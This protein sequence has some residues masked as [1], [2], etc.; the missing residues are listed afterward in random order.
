[1]VETWLELGEQGPSAYAE[2]G[3]SESLSESSATFPHFTYDSPGPLRWKDFPPPCATEPVPVRG[4]KTHWGQWSSERCLPRRWNTRPGFSEATIQWLP[5]WEALVLCLIARLTPPDKAAHSFDR[6]PDSLCNL[7]QLLA[8]L[9]FSHAG[10]GVFFRGGE[11]SVL[12]QRLSH[13]TQA[14]PPG[15][16]PPVTAHRRDQVTFTITSWCVTSWRYSVPS[17]RQTQW[18]TQLTLSRHW[19]FTNVYSM[20]TSLTQM[21]QM[22]MTTS[23]C[24][25]KAHS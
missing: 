12:G 22:C 19:F 21:F 9:G 17:V 15:A 23:L 2:R 13:H 25:V 5:V 11:P 6:W 1:M 18:I 4:R 7:S 20:V 24:S 10:S 14:S 16:A 8:C 3:C